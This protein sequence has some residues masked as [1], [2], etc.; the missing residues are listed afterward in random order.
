MKFAAEKGQCLASLRMETLSIIGRTL[1]EWR[2]SAQKQKILYKL[3]VLKHLH[4]LFA[5]SPEDH[6]QIRTYL[7][8]LRG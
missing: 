7:N 8:K 5:H 1:R 2:I 4:L 3:Q 6:V